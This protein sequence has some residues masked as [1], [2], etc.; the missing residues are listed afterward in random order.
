M[1]L[2]QVFES[3]QF[4]QAGH[5][6]GR[7]N[8]HKHDLALMIAETLIV[9]VEITRLKGRC[10][11]IASSFVSHPDPDQNRTADEVYWDHERDYCEKQ[12]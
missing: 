9:S 4:R 2:I 10:R 11:N 12:T 8:V 6:P 7:P 3:W 1:F 5:A